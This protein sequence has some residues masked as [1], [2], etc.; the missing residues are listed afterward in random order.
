[1]TAGSLW[2]AAR[3]YRW[4]CLQ[5]VLPLEERMG[6]DG[7][8]ALKANLRGWE[9]RIVPGL[10]FYHHRTEGERDR[11]RIRSWS[12]QGRGAHYMRYRP[13]Y[14]TLRSLNYARRDPPAV[15]M[16]AG[17]VQAAVRREP[18]SPDRDMTN[19]LRRRQRF[20]DVPLRALE[21]LGRRGP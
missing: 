18:R 12:A 11:S 1:M 10:S 7:I 20:R 8:D 15:F 3:A 6:W 21:A 13:L 9:T 2:G 14:L 17:F 16:I 5:D 19:E 4:T